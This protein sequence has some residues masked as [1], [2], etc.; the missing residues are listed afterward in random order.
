M[1]GRGSS[2][3]KN[4]GSSEISFKRTDRGISVVDKDGV[5]DVIYLKG[6]KPSVPLN[7]DSAT[8]IHGETRRKATGVGPSGVEYYVDTRYTQV[9]KTSKGIYEVDF[10]SSEG[11]SGQ[12][13]L[14]TTTIPQKVRKRR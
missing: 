10:L 6:K 11:F 4:M 5:K 12:N 13:L 8:K 14:V 7:D 2:G 9:F 1:G 3:G